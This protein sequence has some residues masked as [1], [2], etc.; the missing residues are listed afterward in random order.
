MLKTNI[1]ILFYF[2]FTTIN[3]QT[4]LLNNAVRNVTDVIVHDVF[5]PPAA[6]RIYTYSSI[7]AYQ[8]L[9]P[10]CKNF[11]SLYGKLNEMPVI[12]VP[13]KKETRINYEFASVFAF[14]YTAK[15][16]V[17]SEQLIQYKIDSL[18]VGL[19]IKELSDTKNYAKRVAEKIIEWSSSDNYK[20]TRTFPRYTL[21][22]TPGS[23]QPTAPDYA[24]AVEPYWGELRTFVLDSSDCI[25][26][27]SPTGFS[28]DSN[29]QFYKEAI[30]VYNAI[31][32]LS[33]EQKMV[34]TFWDDNPFTTY[35]VGHMQFAHKK[36]SPAG[37]WLDITRV[38]IES[39]KCDL[40]KAALAYALVSIAMSDAFI[41]CWK[42]K[43]TANTIRPET[44]INKY[45]DELW[46]PYLQT[47][48]FPEYPSGHSA[49]SAASASILTNLFG[50]GFIFTD[51]SETE[52]ELP[53][54]TFISFSEA[55]K[56]VSISRVNGGIHFMPGVING[57]QLGDDIGRYILDRIMLH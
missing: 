30:E 24:D 40:E 47:P 15:S 2:I 8:T 44:Y 45:I 13:D 56:E 18:G 57:Q 41:S 33:E 28:I 6:S 29:S 23:W 1:F 9:E 34:V 32:N 38:A 51:A 14:Y 17:F 50:E 12:P 16:F 35:Y 4:S 43:Y 27:K 26:I 20:E 25:P 7:A 31:N 19:D 3:A 39:T 55:A 46:R 37:H 11:R 22:Q 49:I 36:I 21:L 53:A 42:Q 48:P 10:A 52:F 54:R 5:S